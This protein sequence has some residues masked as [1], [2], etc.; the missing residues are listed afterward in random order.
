VVD[1]AVAHSISQCTGPGTVSICRERG[2]GLGIKFTGRVI[3]H[4]SLLKSV[5][6]VSAVCMRDQP[7]RTSS[8]GIDYTIAIGLIV[9]NLQIGCAL[10]ADQTGYRVCI[11]YQG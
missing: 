9:A 7:R 11:I 3:G 4:L 6:A 1:P 5:P 8:A 2:I 10:F